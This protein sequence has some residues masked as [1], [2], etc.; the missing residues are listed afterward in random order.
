MNI[1]ALDTATEAC[2][3]ALSIQGRVLAR[4]AIAGRSHTEQ[5]IPMVQALMAEAGIG[6]S[7]LDGY[8]CGIG[9]GSF[10]GVRIGLGFMKGLAL[11][12]DRPAVG[13]SSL[14]ALAWPA[15]RDG[16]GRVLAA[17][18]ARMGE[19]YWAGYARTAEAQSLPVIAEQLR[20]PQQ[21]PQVDAGTWRA[22]GT[23]WGTYEGALRQA[24]GAVLS[25]MDGAAL[26]HAEHALALGLPRLTA[27]QGCSLDQ[28]TPR[29][30][31]DKVALTVLEQQAKRA[32]P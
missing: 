23:G 21:V 27:G 24:T 10:A 9:P 5:M 20:A 29:Y 22:V 32:G 12:A 19:V 7:Q 15:L 6:Y 28:L 8:V 3:A 25:A 17:I 13:I 26:P 4:F 14:E 30:L 1:L 16:A 18:D 2:S 31:R 11:A